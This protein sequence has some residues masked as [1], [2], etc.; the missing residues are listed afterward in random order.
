MKLLVTGAVGFIGSHLAECLVARGDEVV[1]LDN[2][3]PSYDLAIK[4]RNLRQLRE[5]MEVVEGDILDAPLLERLFADHRF[6]G[7]IHLAALAGVRRSVEAPWR[8]QRVNVEG[9]ARLAHAMVQHDVGR[10]VFASSS[11]VYGDGLARPSRETDPTESPTSPYAASKRAAE[12]LLHAM[13][14]VHGLEVCALRYFTVF[15]PRQR[16]N[17]AI[18]QF[19][20]AAMRGEPITM[21]GAGDSSRDY[22][23]VDDTVKGTV[24]ALDRAPKGLSTYNIASH[25]PIGLRDMIARIGHAVGAEPIVEQV[26]MP[27]ADVSHTLANIDAAAQDLGYEPATS[28]DEGLRQFVAW[29]RENDD[30]AC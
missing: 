4:Q 30:R 24:L 22:T 10:L 16:P 21:F 8:Y 20:L 2:L 18:Y 3:E 9:T 26:P 6:D 12:L 28:F 13:S 7:V 15:G 5:R 19:S 11:S 27:A 14:H 23:Y 17:M 29:L 1:G 25:R